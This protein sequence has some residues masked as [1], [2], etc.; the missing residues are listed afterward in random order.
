MAKENSKVVIFALD[1]NSFIKL[2]GM[3]LIEKTIRLFS[4]NGFEECVV[5][6]RDNSKIDDFLRRDFKK[7]NKIHLRSLKLIKNEIK[8]LK[9]ILSGDK[10]SFVVLEG[11][12]VYDGR[13]F[14]HLKKGMHAGHFQYVKDE[15][16]DNTPYIFWINDKILRSR[17]VKNEHQKI[18]DFVKNN[19]SIKKVYTKDMDCYIIK[20]RRRMV[21]Y[22]FKIDDSQSLKKAELTAFTSV[23]KGATDFITKYFYP[24]P[25][26]WSVKLL[27][28]T[29]ITPNHI[30]FVSMILSFGAIPFYFI[31]WFWTAIIMGLIMSLLD[32]IDGKLAR[33]TIRISTSGDLMD[34]IS[35]IV[36]LP[37][38]YFGVGWYLSK[39]EIFN[40][41]LNIVLAIWGVVVFYFIDRAV[42]GLFKKIYNVELHDYTNLDSFFRIYV[43]RRNPFLLVMII[44]MIFINPEFGLY[45]TTIWTMITFI[46]HF[47]RFIYL[48]LSGKKHQSL[49]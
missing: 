4:Q 15:L 41:N 24:I 44:S 46:F 33:L 17:G 37:I 26:R 28:P 19:P 7:W 3:T 32:S 34:H 16:N 20:L 42:L 1:E 30:T 38:W 31:G 49:V 9:F 48:P 5:V 27:S 39:G 12:G 10:S 13:I 25:V 2:W 36:Y 43:A 23:Y 40:F 6:F 47:I 22:L 11:N 35:D 14:E 18:E 29:I 8:T 21:P 45:T